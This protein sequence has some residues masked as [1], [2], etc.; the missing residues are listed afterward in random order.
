[1]QAFEVDTIIEKDGT[2]HLPEQYR[3]IFGAKARM[4]VLF[5]EAQKENQDSKGNPNKL[6]EFSGTIDWSIDDPVE[7]QRKLRSEWDREWD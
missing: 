2:V 5:E 7:F 4:I 1:M 3:S 6:M